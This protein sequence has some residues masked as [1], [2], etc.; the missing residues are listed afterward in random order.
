VSATTS[1]LDTAVQKE[2]A[3]HLAVSGRV[4]NKLAARSAMVGSMRG[5]LEKDSTEFAEQ[6]LRDDTQHVISAY[7]ASLASKKKK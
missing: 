4:L 5:R 3:K 7:L 2:I 1:E 6:I